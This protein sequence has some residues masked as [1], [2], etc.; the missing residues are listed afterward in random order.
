MKLGPTGGGAG[1]VQAPRL[2]GVDVH[3]P[4]DA[5]RIGVGA[6]Q[7]VERLVFGSVD[8]AKTSG[9]RWPYLGLR[10]S[11]HGID[12]RGVRDR[13]LAHQ[14]KTVTLVQPLI[15]SS[16]PTSGTPAGTHSAAPPPRVPRT[17]ARAA[18]THQRSVRKRWLRWAPLSIVRNHPSVDPVIDE[19]TAQC[20]D[21]LVPFVVGGR[22]GVD[23]VWRGHG[24]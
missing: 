18:S 3:R 13:K 8:G 21:D 9:G 4:H 5:L 11:P 22:M 16:S 23:D 2:Y 15:L 1:H 20:G 17:P 14:F 12:C 24:T 7:Q 10:W 6:G 19:R